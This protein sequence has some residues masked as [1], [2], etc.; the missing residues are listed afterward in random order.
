MREIHQGE[1]FVVKNKNTSIL[2]KNSNKSTFR[3][4]YIYIYIYIYVNQKI[5]TNTFSGIRSEE[6]MQSTV[7][8]K[9]E[10]LSKADNIVKAKIHLIKLISNSLGT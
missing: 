9:L 2:P 5:A 7:K 10:N 1:D 8:K 4:I 3:R 6:P